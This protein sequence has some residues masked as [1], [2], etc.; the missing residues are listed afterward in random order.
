MSRFPW[1]NKTFRYNLLPVVK[2]RKPVFPTFQGRSCCTSHYVSSF[3]E[4]LLALQSFILLHIALRVSTVPPFHDST[5]P[6]FHNSSVSQVRKCLRRGNR[7]R[8]FFRCSQG[9]TI[10]G[11]CQPW[12]RQGHA[13]TLSRTSPVGQQAPANR[14]PLYLEF[15]L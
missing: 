5:I 15:V 10:N 8:S 3:L 2:S 14:D 7:R 9:N 13:V 11:D 6:Q 12:K 4:A 1:Y